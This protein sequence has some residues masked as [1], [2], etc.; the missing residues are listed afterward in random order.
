MLSVKIRGIGVSTGGVDTSLMMMKSV[1][2]LLCKLSVWKGAHEGYYP[3]MTHDGRPLEV[4]KTV[5]KT[6][7]IPISFDCVEGYTEN[8]L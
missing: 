8:V 4:V 7:A 6:K 5:N 1:P 2:E 3:N